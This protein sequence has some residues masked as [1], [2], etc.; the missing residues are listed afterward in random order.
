MPPQ[1][2]RGATVSGNVKTMGGMPMPPQTLRGATV[3]GNV[4]TM[5]GMPMP[6]QT[7]RGATV[8]GNVKTMGRMPMPPQASCW[9]RT[10]P[11]PTRTE[12]TVAGLKGRKIL[13]QGNALG[14]KELR[15]TFPP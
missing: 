11:T 2:L 7:L 8:S 4:K 12:P 13:A 10:G 9:A 5:G 3:S 1:T 14:I 6:P 15:N